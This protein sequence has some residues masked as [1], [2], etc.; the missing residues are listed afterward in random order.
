MYEIGAVSNQDKKVINIKKKTCVFVL[1]MHRSGTSAITRVLNFVGCSLPA[2]IMAENQYNSKG[3]WE[4]LEIC[5]L[6]D[7]M[8]KSAGS[9]WDDWLPVSEDWFNS[10]ISYS[11][12]KPASDILHSEFSE[13]RL[14][15]LKD[16]R[17]CRLAPFW[18]DVLKQNDIQTLVVLPIRNPLE[19]A[20]SL[21]NRDALDKNYSLLM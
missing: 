21:L 12:V 18:L 14:F 13:S 8:L 2:N 9:K 6:N 3:Y 19:V 16:P 17:C 5:R 4:S 10:P 15:V 20:E 7:E 11:Y 1:G